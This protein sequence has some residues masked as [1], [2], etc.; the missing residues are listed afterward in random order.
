M[1]NQPHIVYISPYYNP[2]VA[3]G[4]NRRFDEICKRFAEEFGKSF[5]LVVSR[6]NTPKWW[7]GKGNLVEVSPSSNH[8]TKFRTAYDIGRV[9]DKLPPS[10]VVIE[11]IPIPFRALRRHTHLQVVYDFRYFTADSKGLLYRMAFSRFLRSQWRRSEHI[12][13]CTDFSISELE[14]Y[15]GFERK[16]IIKSYFGIDTNLL[17]SPQGQAKKTIDIF[18]VG[19]FEKRKNHAPLLQAIAKVDPTLRAV[20]IGRDNGMQAETEALAQSLG[21]KNATFGSIEGDAAL[22]DAYRESR[23]FVYPSIYE[24]FGIPLIEALALQTPVICSDTAV[25]HEVGDGFADYFDPKDPDD[26]ADKIKSALSKERTHEYAKVRSYLEKFTWDNIYTKFV[27]DLIE[28][29]QNK[30]KG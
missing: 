10:I 4:A 12:V 29:T 6:G 16:Q 19:H 3:S 15:V 27:K 17:G 20:F 30:S 26:I 21:L 5:T 24:G 7:N 18:Y 9:L 22:W 23:L 13:T 14:K 11:S 8:L 28:T 25:F 2:S 1:N